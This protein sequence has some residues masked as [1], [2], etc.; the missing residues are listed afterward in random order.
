MRSSTCS[1]A[2]SRQAAASSPGASS[3]SAC[4]ASTPPL[5]SRNSTPAGRGP[6][7]TSSR[8]DFFAVSTSRL[9][10][11]KP[12]ATSTSVNTSATCSAIATVTGRFTAITPPNAD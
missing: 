4:W 5:I 8:S 10:S 2:V 11:R 1:P 12:G 6:A 7:T 3:R 9:P